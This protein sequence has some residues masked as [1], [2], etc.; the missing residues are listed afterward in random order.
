MA[1]LCC[2]GLFANSYWYRGVDNSWGATAMTVSTDGLY[3]YIQSSSNANQFKIAASADGWDYNHSYVQAGFNSTDVTNIGDYGQDNCYCWQSGSYYILV[4]Y[5]NTAVNTTANPIICASTTLPEASASDEMYVW[6]GVGVTTA[7]AATEEGGTAEAV[8]ADGTNIVVGASQKGNWCLKA[9]KGFSSGAYYIGIA[10]DN[11]VNAGDTVKIAYFRTTTSS[12]YVLGMDFSAAKASAATTYQILTKGDPQAL[13]SNGTPV[14]SI[15]I[16]PEGVKDAKYIR[17]YRNSGSTGTW[18]AKFE[19]VKKVAAPE[20]PAPV[21]STTLYFVNTNDWAKVFAYVFTDADP[22]P[23]Y[24]TWPGEAM[25]KTNDK[26]L[27]KDVYKYTFPSSFTTIIFN[28]KEDGTTGEQ[29]ANEQWNAA[30][31]YYADGE[32]YASLDEITP[33]VP[34]KFYVTGDSALVVDA[35]FDKSIAWHSDAIKSEKDTIELNLK[36][37]QNYQLQV[38]VGGNAWKGYS[39][40]SIKADGLKAG[41]EYGNDICFSLSE[42]GKVKVV[43]FVENDQETFEL[44]GNF[45]VKP[46][47][48]KDIFLVPNQWAEGEAKIA[49]W[50]WNKAKTINVFTDFFAPK[51][52][53]N[54]TLVAKVLAEVDSIIFVRFN[55]T[56]TEPKWDGGEGYQWNQTPDDSIQWEKA[57][58]TILPTEGYMT[59]GTWDVYTPAQP[60][61]ADGFYLI[62][63]KGWEVDS[64]SADLLFAANPDNAGEYQ[65]TVN[66]VKDDKIKVVKVENDVIKHW[67]PDGEGNEY[68]VDVAHEGNKT[69]YFKPDYVEAWADFGGY[70]FIEANHGTG[71]DKLADDAQA[72]KAMINGQLFIIR[73]GKTYTVQGAEVR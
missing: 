29:S 25:I 61:L 37:G 73:D 16:V 47:V 22:W 23:H 32:W 3:E 17:I 24:K 67:Y 45:Y 20:P 40:L 12:T 35:G 72:V 13:T 65:L 27:G 62:G 56:A 33:V 68:T 18:V 44:I 39:D 15:Y 54:D 2:A 69:I 38:V 50:T 53:G 46:V 59:N 19:L 41:G 36:G 30:K 10:L 48:K 28:S 51:A 31:P 60:R 8:Q 5:P 55:A 57:V 9:N 21:D 7:A 66:L 43:Y 58:Y 6:N 42:A 71:L 4:Y 1:V 52:E 34:A 26:A 49:A 63:Q 14:D 70:F 11:A 64:I